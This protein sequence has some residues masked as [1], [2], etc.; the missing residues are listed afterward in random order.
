MW[1]GVEEINHGRTPA[2]A[3]ATVGRRTPL[4]N[5]RVLLDK[6]ERRCACG[7]AVRLPEAEGRAAKRS[8]EAARYATMPRQS[9]CGALGTTRPTKNK[10]GKRR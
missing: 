10:K 6:G 3:K 1:A 2:Y 4:A 7:E 8:Q 9:N 5:V